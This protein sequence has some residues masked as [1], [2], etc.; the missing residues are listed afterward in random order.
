MLETLK[1]NGGLPTACIDR[2]SSRLA[3]DVLS[4]PYSTTQIPANTANRGPPDNL[5]NP[6][7]L[8]LCLS[9]VSSII[10]AL[11]PQAQS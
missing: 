10:L 3:L 8:S 9:H 4:K 2:Y 5:R 1:L 11:E 7:R 6:Q